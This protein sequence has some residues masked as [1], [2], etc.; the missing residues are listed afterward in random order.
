MK[1]QQTHL[2]KIKCSNETFDINLHS[3]SSN[4]EYIALV[5]KNGQVPAKS[6]GTAGIG[7]YFGDKKVD[8]IKTT[9]K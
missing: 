2:L 9:V 6:K 7:L 8:S 4:N 1:E 3:W 5:E